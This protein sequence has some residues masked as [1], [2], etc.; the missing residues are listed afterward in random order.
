M[1]VLKHIKG[2]VG[3]DVKSCDAATSPSILRVITN[4]SLDSSCRSSC[5]AN[6]RCKM[7]TFETTNRS[8][9]HTNVNSPHSVVDTHHTVE[10]N[11]T[12]TTFVKSSC[13]ANCASD[14]ARSE[15]VVAGKC[16]RLMTNGKCVDEIP[17]SGNA[18]IDCRACASESQG[19]TCYKM[20]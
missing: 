11:T 16:T 8:C 3:L 10:R 15:L 20:I 12:I 18:P 13:N 1:D 14:D 19:R 9:V 2:N 4:D 6:P 7:A 5:E 17:S